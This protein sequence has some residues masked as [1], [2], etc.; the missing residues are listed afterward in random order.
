M[1][2]VLNIDWSR[3]G[4]KWV[5]YFDLL[6]F[7]VFVDKHPPESVFAL[8]ETCIEEFKRQEKQLPQLEYVHFSDTFLVYARNDSAGSFAAIDM[9]SRWFVNHLI[10]RQDK[11][12]A[13]YTNTLQ[14]L[15][16]FGVIQPA[17]KLGG[18]AQQSERMP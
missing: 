11:V 14:F 1:T 4:K 3:V 9:V 8:Y 15:N 16:H 17:T 5:A 10:Q 6:G 12:K 13:K 18:P 7:G 2:D